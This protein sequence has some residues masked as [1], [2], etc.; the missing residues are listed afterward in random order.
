VLSEY[1]LFE[2]DASQAETW[3]HRPVGGYGES[4]RKPAGRRLVFA[5]E[6]AL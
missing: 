5:T 6:F 1:E 4:T 3:L 2:T